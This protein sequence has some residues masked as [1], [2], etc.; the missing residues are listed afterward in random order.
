MAPSQRWS[1]FDRPR[2]G[3][4]QKF[5]VILSI[6]PLASVP[7]VGGVTPLDHPPGGCPFIVPPSGTYGPHYTREATRPSAAVAQE[8]EL[9]WRQSQ[10]P[11]RGLR[12]WRRSRSP[13]RTLPQAAFVETHD[14]PPVA[15]AA[16][17]L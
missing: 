7:G 4:R 10:A 1:L 6:S 12:R 9:A 8:I 11:G 2:H 17:R 3:W 13:P 15:R 14:S 5:A 16:R